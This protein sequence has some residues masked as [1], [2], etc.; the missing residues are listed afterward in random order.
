MK[1]NRT[2]TAVALSLTLSIPVLAIAKDLHMTAQLLTSSEVPPKAGNGH[3]ALTAVYDTSS[4][5]LKWKVG[6]ADLSGPASMAHFHDPA[7]EGK[8]A[9]VV[10]P[11][12]KTKL[13]TP[14]EGQAT[15][16]DEQERDL[17]AGNWYFNIHTAQNP[18]GE[19]RGQVEEAK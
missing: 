19:I 13:S 9:G 16:T 2:L 3:G 7:P 10:I 18:G 12:D 11:I 5:V 1:L 17:L 15:L 8:N 4:K 14:I 6:Y